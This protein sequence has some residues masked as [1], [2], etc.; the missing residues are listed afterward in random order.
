MKLTKK[1]LSLT[2]FAIGVAS[3][4][5]SHNVTVYA[6]VWVGSTEV[7]AGEYQVQVDN[8][9]A[10]FKNNKNK[11]DVVEVP[12]AV[13]T[14]DKKFSATALN[15]TTTNGKAKLEAIEIGGSKTRI[16]MQAAGGAGSN[17][18]E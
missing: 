1:L 8:G 18:G 14:S 6:P 10:I 11:K 5:S 3:A 15:T 9:K 17:A 2:V 13:E 12:A 4:A 16:V 7:K